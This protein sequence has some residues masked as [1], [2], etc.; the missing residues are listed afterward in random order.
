MEFLL[1]G[2]LEV[3]D[4]DRVVALGGV[5]QRALLAL[6]LLNANRVVP[7]DRLIDELWGEDPPKTA[8]ASV[9]V[10]VS[11][12]RKLLLPGVLVTRAPGYTLEVEPDALDL[13]RFELLLAEARG[14]RSEVAARLLREALGLWRGPPLAE[15]AEE[16]FA[17]VEAG[18]LEELR[19]GALEERISAELELGRDLELV[20]ELEA[21]VPQHPHRERFRAQLM[22]ALYRAG[23]QADALQAY[24][25]ARAALGELGLEPSV[26]L[27][28]LEQQILNQAGALE[29]AR[30]HLLRDD[31]A[32]LPGPLVPES[33]FPFVGRAQ[34]RA[35]LAGLLERAVGG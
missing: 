33:P 27:R 12:L 2:P 7:R 17:R 34:E 4:G 30:G 14:A 28:Q 35:E 20:G 21:L 19:L 18:R 31:R 8:L 23:R 26:A 32:P 9:Q 1:L 5:K 10:Y 11:R 22:L 15:F 6:L 13:A 25:A 29:V 16:P 3:R 24:R